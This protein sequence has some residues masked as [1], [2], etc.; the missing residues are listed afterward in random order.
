MVCTCVLCL[1]TA[2]TKRIAHFVFRALVVVCWCCWYTYFYYHVGYGY[3]LSMTLVA[4]VP[5]KCQLLHSHCYIFFKS[6]V[7]TNT[8]YTKMA[9]IIIAPARPSYTSECKLSRCETTFFL[10]YILRKEIFIAIPGSFLLQP[11][12]LGVPKMRVLSPPGLTWGR[13]LCESWVEYHH[14]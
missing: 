9:G 1:S 14:T 2:G 10:L 12:H 6:Q 13:N 5:S 11:K 4:G 7:K 3:G 8:T